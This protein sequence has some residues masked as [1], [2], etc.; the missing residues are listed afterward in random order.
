[1][2]FE[3]RNYA[4]TGAFVDELARSGLRHVCVCPGSR[5]SPLTISFARHATIKT[6][7]HLDERSASFFALGIAL[8]L[9]EPVAVVCTSGTAAANFHPAVVEARYASVP[10]L[11]LTADR[12]PELSEWGANQTIDQVR[13]YGAHVKWSVSMPPPEV[14]ASLMAFVRS[15]ACRAYAIAAAAP[16]GPVHVNFPF[17]DPLDPAVVPGDVPPQVEQHGDEAWHGR[18]GGRP[19]VN[20]VDPEKRL[21]PADMQSLAAELAGIERGLIVCGPQPSPQLGPAVAAL[22]QRLGFPILADPLSQ[23]RCGP[24]DRSLVVDSY[25]TFLRDTDLA[26][27]LAPELIL[28][29]GAAPASRPLGQ[30]L[31]RR[32]AARHVLVDSGSGWSDPWHATSLRLDVGPVL[33]CTQLAAAVADQRSNHAWSDRWRQVAQASRKAIRQEMDGLQE[34]SEGKVF[35]ELARL[36]PDDAILFV[37]NSMPVRD[38]ESFFPSTAQRIRFLANRGASGIDGVVST[39]LGVSAVADQRVVLVLGDLSFYHDMNG[40]LAAKAHR[41]NATIIVLNNDGG[42][43]FSFLPQASYEDLFEPYFGTPHG[44]TFQAAAHLYGIEYRLVQDWQQFQ[45]TVAEHLTG[46]GARIIEVPSHRGRNL[47]H[48]RRIQEKALDSL[49]SRAGTER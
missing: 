38:L 23:V 16:H 39:A 13:M 35:S 7:V 8:A 48:H 19:F 12:P 20:A 37:G 24:H 49:R 46:T 31:E 26:E 21:V 34:L 6:W 14:T 41:L 44:L 32:R 17:R 22:A 40:L 28:R 11:V 9:G 47:A 2:P 5:S 3:N 27:S 15:T 29:L 36:L 42:G 43:I 45:Q 33:F 4:F 25:D 30:Y 1:M 10:L 18:A